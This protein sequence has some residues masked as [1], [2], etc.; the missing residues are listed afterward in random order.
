MCL[1]IGSEPL[2]DQA[3]CALASALKPLEPQPCGLEVHLLK[4]P[5]VAVHSE[6]L[7]MP[8]QSPAERGVL[9][10]KLQVPVTPTPFAEGCEEPL[11]LRRACLHARA[12]S[13]LARPAPVYREAEEVE[14]PG[15]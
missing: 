9:V 6:V 5:A 13:S 2:P 8:S 11:N 1:E 15:S 7:E 10:H 4:A 14:R 12:P 3:V